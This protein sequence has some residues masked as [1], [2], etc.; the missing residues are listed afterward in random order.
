MAA[1]EWQVKLDTYADGELSAAEMRA[2]DNHLR[3]CPSCA[4]DLLNRVQMK[5]AVQAAGRRYTP[6]A[7]FRRKIENKVAARKRVM[8]RLWQRGR[9]AA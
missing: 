9:A 3:G 6:S 2:L 8:R 4:A 5:R 1:D 7:E